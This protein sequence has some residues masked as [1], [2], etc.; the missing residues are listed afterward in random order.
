MS[1]EEFEQIGRSR[2]KAGLDELVWVAEHIRG[3]PREGRVTKE[4]DALEHW[5][6]EDR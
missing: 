1:S 2:L 3:G 4:E 6:A 5:K